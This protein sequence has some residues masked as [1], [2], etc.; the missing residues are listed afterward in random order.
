MNN[1][2][3]SQFKV[4]MANESRKVEYRV[5][6]ANLTAARIIALAVHSDMRIL[7]IEEVK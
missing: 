5:N 2:Y 6:C 7:H 1:I 3:V 4:M